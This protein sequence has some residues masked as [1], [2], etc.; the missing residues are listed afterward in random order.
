MLKLF[1]ICHHIVIT[2]ERQTVVLHNLPCLVIFCR[3]VVNQTLLA[4]DKV[5]VFTKLLFSMD[6]IIVNLSCS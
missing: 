4:N 2:L 6:M 3:Y 1:F 5:N